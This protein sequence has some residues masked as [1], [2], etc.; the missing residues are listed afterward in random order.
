MKKIV[1]RV[2]FALA[3]AALGFAYYSFISC[4]SGG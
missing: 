1:K 4:S 3:G 2:S